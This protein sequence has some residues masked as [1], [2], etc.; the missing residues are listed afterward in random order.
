MNHFEFYLQ[1]WTVFLLAT[2]YM[3]SKLVNLH[4]SVNF[5]F[6]ILKILRIY[7]QKNGLL[8]NW[9]CVFE[10]LWKLVTLG[11]KVKLAYKL[12]IGIA[13]GRDSFWTILNLQIWTLFWLSTLN[14]SQV[15]SKT[16]ALDLDHQDQINL[17]SSTVFEK[18][19][20]VFISRA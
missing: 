11:F 18:N 1:K 17:Q 12:N 4:F 7:Q 19:W 3:S 10:S 15:N 2:R 14:M 8:S 6:K 9:N 5:P 20:T 13:C 16:G